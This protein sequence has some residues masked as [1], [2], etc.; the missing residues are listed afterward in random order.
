MIASA[1]LTALAGTSTIT[2][3]G[4]SQREVGVQPRGI[5]EGLLV[6]E[7]HGLVGDR[8][9]VVVEGPGGDRVGDC[10]DEQLCGRGRGPTGARRPPTRGG[11][12]APGTGRP[13]SP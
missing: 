4:S 5:G 2:A 9:D 3:S 8:D 7:Q 13:S 10:C 6:S 12:G 11:S 1:R